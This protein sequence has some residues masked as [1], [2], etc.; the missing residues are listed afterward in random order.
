MKTVF[1]RGFYAM[2]MIILEE[3]EILFLSAYI[4]LNRDS[5]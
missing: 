1:C 2:Q 3:I 5:V 4:G